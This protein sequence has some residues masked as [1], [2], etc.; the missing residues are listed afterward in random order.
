MV[1][2]K[3]SVKKNNIELWRIIFTFGVAIMHFG[4]YNGFYISVDFFFMLTGFLLCKSVSM[5]KEKSVGEVL[6]KRM[7]RLAPHYWLSFLMLLIWKLNNYKTLGMVFDHNFATDML[8]EVGFL[9]TLYQYSDNNVNGIA[10]YVSVMTIWTPLLIVA[11]KHCRKAYT[12]IIAPYSAL[13]IYAFFLINWGHI[14]FGFVW[15]GWCNGGLLRGLAGMNAGVAAYVL[16]EKLSKYKFANWFHNVLATWE[17]V[18][19]GIVISY[20]FH[21]RQTKFDF[22]VIGIL[23]LMILNGF[24]EEGYLVRITNNKLVAYI[25]KLCYAVYLN[26]LFVM[27]LLGYF[28]IENETAKL[29]LYV[30]ALIIC[31]MIFTKFVQVGQKVVAKIWEKAKRLAVLSDDRE[32]D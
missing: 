1:D 13:F 20:A 6:G 24:L 32:I 7:K 21:Y 29:I 31:S 23:F 11:L 16:Y 22:V 8:L 14:D 30:L 28:K 18:C 12:Y 26:Q 3:I 4:Y 5:G 10:W 17:I 9:Q 25:G 2:S 27:L 15:I 19:A